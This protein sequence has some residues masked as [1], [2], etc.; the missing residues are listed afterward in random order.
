M[1]EKIVILVI[2]DINKINNGENKTRKN[3]GQK[4]V[5]HNVCD[6]IYHISYV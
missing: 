4:M 6:F 2:I 3:K 5:G 1:H